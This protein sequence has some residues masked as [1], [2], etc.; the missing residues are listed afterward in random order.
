M[1]PRVTS[2]TPEAAQKLADNFYEGV[3]KVRAHFF[4]ARFD[5][6]YDPKKP[7]IIFPP[8]GVGASA[9]KEALLRRTDFES[10]EA[11]LAAD[12]SIKAKIRSSFESSAGKK[13]SERSIARVIVGAINTTS[14]YDI[15]AP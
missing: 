14:A 2:M 13:Q 4:A 7:L 6:I 1:F 12:L 3:A 9:Y 8:K 15:Q 10:P 11:I 5:N